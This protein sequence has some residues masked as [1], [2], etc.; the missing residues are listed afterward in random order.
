VPNKSVYKFIPTRGLKGNK[1]K[2]VELL[3]TDELAY[4]KFKKR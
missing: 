1:E 2:L 3:Q 4:L